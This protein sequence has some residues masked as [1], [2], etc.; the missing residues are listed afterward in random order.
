MLQPTGYSCLTQKPAIRIGIGAKF[1]QQDLDRERALDIRVADAQNRP[2]PA[3]R[4]F[5]LH[6]ITPNL[7]RQQRRLALRNC[8]GR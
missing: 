6:Q 1:G 8:S 2:H 7:P 4:Y 5:L 3:A